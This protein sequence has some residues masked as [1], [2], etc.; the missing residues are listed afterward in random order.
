[1]NNRRKS[2]GRSSEGPVHEIGDEPLSIDDLFALATGANV[3]C[4]LDR[5]IML[6]CNP[7]ENAGLPADL[8]GVEGPEACAH[9]GFG[10]PE[11]S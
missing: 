8:V 4:L 2:E 3:A 1:M 11:I 9:N 7:A 6:L 5:Q 10:K